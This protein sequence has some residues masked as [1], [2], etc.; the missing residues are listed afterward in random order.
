VSRRAARE[1]AAHRY[2]DAGWHVFP[3]EPG[4]KR[5]ATE[6]GY[7]DATT[8]HKQIQNW[9]RA[10]PR[11]NLAVATGAPGPDVLDVDK[12]KEGD[13]F[14]AFNQLKQAGLVRE[15]MAIVRTPSG[16]FHAY[17]KGTEHQRNGHIPGV[18]VDFR[19]QGGYVVAPPSRIA[20]REYEVAR[21]H[22][23]ADTFDWAAAKKLLDPQPERQP[24]RAP[25][26]APGERADYTGMANWLASQAPDGRNRNE[27]LFWA[28]CRVVEAGDTDALSR[29]ADAARAT[30]L[31][32]RE[33]GR[34]I[35]S[36]QQTA[37][38]GGGQ[39]SFEHSRAAAPAARAL[40]LQAEAEAGAL[41]PRPASRPAVASHR[42]AGHQIPSTWK[43]SHAS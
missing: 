30:G 10:E 22:A 32:E 26:R 31:D 6:H 24:Y 34:T 5:P 14:S 8:S 1:E 40:D 21:K 9:W 15:P 19:S 3:A 33:I 16:G 11:S 35:A 7:L 18:C 23:S 17:Y 38:R 43:E 13:G 28:S 41:E 42:P 25:E 12:H 29:L 36:A 37:G 20:G 39:R 4:G 27:A 2:A